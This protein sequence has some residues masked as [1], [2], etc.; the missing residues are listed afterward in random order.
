[1]TS[2]GLLETSIE[3]LCFMLIEQSI[4]D[5]GTSYLYMPAAESVALNSRLRTRLEPLIQQGRLIRGRAWTTDA[6]FREPQSS[7]DAMRNRGA[8]AVEM[9]Y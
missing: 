1:M 2:A 6:P 3:T 4:R 7:I 5:E 9:E 8:V